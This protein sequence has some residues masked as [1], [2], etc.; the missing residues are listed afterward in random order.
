M[1]V[2]LHLVITNYHIGRETLNK[3][4]ASKTTTH[5]TFKIFIGLH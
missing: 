1:S 3:D 2:H 5:L 4:N